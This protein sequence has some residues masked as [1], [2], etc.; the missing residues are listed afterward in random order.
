V[1]WEQMTQ[2]YHR[3]YDTSGPKLSTFLNAFR[4]E[5]YEGPEKVLRSCEEAETYVRHIGYRML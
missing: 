5:P 2:E 4:E 1:E 3:S